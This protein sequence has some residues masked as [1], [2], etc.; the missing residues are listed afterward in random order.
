MPFKANA[1]R[2]HG[3]VTAG[4]VWS[5]VGYS[6][7]MTSLSYSGHRFPTAIIQHAIWIYLWT[8]PA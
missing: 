8:V 5:Q 1:D 7:R 2:R 4:P 3:I 6:G